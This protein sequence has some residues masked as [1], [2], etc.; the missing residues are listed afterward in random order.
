MIWAKRAQINQENRGFA[1]EASFLTGIFRK[2][3][4]PL[5]PRVHRVSNEQLVTI[6]NVTRQDH[7]VFL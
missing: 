1:N 7:E 2:G 6:D 5:L 3:E 4:S